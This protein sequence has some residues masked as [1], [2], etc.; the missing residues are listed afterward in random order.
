[1]ELFLTVGHDDW[2][3]IPYACPVDDGSHAY[4][5]LRSHPECIDE[6][7]EAEAFPELRQFLRVINGPDSFFR[8]LACFTIPQ[9]TDYPA[10]PFEMRSYIDITFKPWAWGYSAT[11]SFAVFLKFTRRIHELECD[12]KL[13]AVDN[14]RV[15]CNLKTGNQQDLKISFWSMEWWFTTV[16]ETAE[17]ARGEWNATLQLLQEFLLDISPDIEQQFQFA[18]AANPGKAEALP[19]AA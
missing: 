5:D 7:P 10:Q 19:E 1:M 14:V 13:E 3:A 12:K 15:Y 18:E 6:I 9:Q 11:H 8:T 2:L 4:T 16:G 17:S